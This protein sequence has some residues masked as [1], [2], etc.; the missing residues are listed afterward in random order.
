MLLFYKVDII[1][2]LRYVKLDLAHAC[3]YAMLG[4]FLFN[5][6]GGVVYYWNCFVLRQRQFYNSCTGFIVIFLSLIQCCARHATSCRVNHFK[7]CYTDY[8]SSYFNKLKTE[9][10]KWNFINNMRK[11]INWATKITSIKNCFGDIITNPKQIGKL[12]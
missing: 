7:R 2:I 6:E 10:K 11:S 3:N 1:A 8:N 4:H 12:V 5:G 9:K